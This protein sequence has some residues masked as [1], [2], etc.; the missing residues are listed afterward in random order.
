MDS[1]SIIGLLAFIITAVILEY[2][3]TKA[4]KFLYKEYREPKS[5]LLPYRPF[6]LRS[7][8][9]EDPQG[10]R[11]RNKAVMIFFLWVIFIII[12]VIIYN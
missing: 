11:Y 1:R 4:S 9:Y 8:F 2:F 5:T 7:K 3:K 12:V 10:L 6:Y